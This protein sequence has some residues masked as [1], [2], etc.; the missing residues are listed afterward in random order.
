M[1]DAGAPG[2]RF[3]GFEK[4]RLEALADG[5]FAVA[6]TLLV[7]D[8]KLPD[9]MTAATS[10]DLWRNLVSL[11]RHF[12]VYAISFVVIGVY[13]VGHH[14]QFHY[15]RFVDRRLIWIN[16]T[17]L[18]L[19]TFLPFATDL[20]GDHPELVLPCEIYGITLLTIGGVSHAQ[21][22]YLARHPYLTSD[23]LTPVA[24]RLLKRRIALLAIV[25]AVSML[26]ALYNTRF[27]LYAYGLV[28]VAYLMPS[29][30]GETAFGALQAGWRRKDP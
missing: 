6:L 4:N 13:W 25:P 7:L 26:L 22:V 14:L 10:D 2:G 9:G 18:L 21:V 28:V 12:A 17:F 20:V 1:S 24:I 27:A 8:I 16:L 3:R 19:I 15:V 5:I 11:E 23:E 29:R 30:A